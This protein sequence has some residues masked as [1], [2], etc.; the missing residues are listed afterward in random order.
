MKIDKERMAV[1]E[2]STMS[3][4]KHSSQRPLRPAYCHHILLAE[5]D[6]EMRRMLAWSLHQEGYE[7]TECDDGYCLMKQLCFWG[8][9]RKTQNY[10]LV[11]SD[12][13]MP[14]VTG[15]QVLE[16]AREFEDFP[17]MI[18]ITAF[19]DDSTRTQAERFGAVAMFDK[20]FEILD[21]LAEIAQILRPQ[22]PSGKE[23]P[24]SSTDEGAEVQFPMDI[25]FR[26]KCGSESLKVFVR[27]M[28]SKF[29]RYAGRILHCQV[30]IDEPNAHRQREH[31][32]YVNVNMTLPGETVVVKHQSDNVWGYEDT[33]LA[34]RVTFGKVYH[35][36]KHRLDKHSRKKEHCAKKYSELLTEERNHETEETTQ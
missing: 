15:L 3:R 24:L 25:A 11:I 22:M 30:V 8:P 2:Y 28:A 16:S 10:D 32:Y 27:Q 20:P 1:M 35:Q 6:L 26:H 33:Y 31:Q 18:L 17:P 12:I 5:D 21:L 14:G 4:Q 34:V 23:Q 29:N 13:R 9:L 36:L 7:V 19:G